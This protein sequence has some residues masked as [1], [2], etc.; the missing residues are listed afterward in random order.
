MLSQVKISR[1]HFLPGYS[2]GLGERTALVD[3]QFTGQMDDLAAML[4]TFA[5][6][7]RRLCPSELLWGLG[8]HGWPA[9]FVQDDASQN[10][11]VKVAVIEMPR[12]GLIRLGHPCD[13]YDVAALLN[14]QDDHIGMDGIASLLQM[15]ELK[16]EVLERAS[17]AVVINAE[18]T[19]CLGMRA[20]IRR[21]MCWWRVL[22]RC[23]PSRRTGLTVW[24][25]CS[26]SLTRGCRGS[27]WLKARRKRH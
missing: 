25:R 16:A 23:R 13:R 26:C 18:D 11:A 12:K 27:F 20:R 24:K 21:A 19:L 10:P 8:H 1:L 5:E 3:L 4:P 14:V 15:A 7:A 22:R 2:A 6:Q 9:A 17:Q